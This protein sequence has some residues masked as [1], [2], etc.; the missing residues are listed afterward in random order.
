MHTPL[1]N[2]N[3]VFSV[4]MVYVFLKSDHIN[5]TVDVVVSVLQPVNAY[6]QFKPQELEGL[7]TFLP[8][9]LVRQHPGLCLKENTLSDK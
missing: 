2:Q 6:N 7:N 9:Q 5:K 8:T 1:A 3:Q 4:V